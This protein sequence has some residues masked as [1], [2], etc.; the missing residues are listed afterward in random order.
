MLTGRVSLTRVWLDI[1]YEVLMEENV[2]VRIRYGFIHTF[3]LQLKFDILQ[4][5]DNAQI[6]H[7]SK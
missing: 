1:T 3:I 6:Q 5:W 4:N 2:T 7:S